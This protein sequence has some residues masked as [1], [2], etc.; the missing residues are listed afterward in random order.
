MLA[1]FSLCIP[2][3]GHSKA[4]DVPPHPPRTPMCS[5]FSARHALNPVQ[6][7]RVST[8]G[9]FSVK[10]GRVEVEAKVPVGDWIWPAIWLMPEVSQCW[11]PSR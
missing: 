4:F 7:A 11:K 1:P 10:Y 9:R 5:S 8:A 2:L 6:S 3:C